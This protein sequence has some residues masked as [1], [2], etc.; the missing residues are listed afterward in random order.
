MMQKK[1]YWWH[2]SSLDYARKYN[3]EV[4]TKLIQEKLT[5]SNLCT[6]ANL[7][8]IWGRLAHSRA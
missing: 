7:P 3:E 8:H 4:I 5:Y 6:C 1:W 2:M